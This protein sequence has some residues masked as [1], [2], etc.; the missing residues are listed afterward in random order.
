MS[1]NLEKFTVKSR[2]AL[3]ESRELAQKMNH[4]EI[5]PEHLLFALCH[6]TDGVVPPL[7]QKIGVEPDK[8][9]NHSND[10]LKR[11]PSVTGDSNADIY[12]SRDSSS[13]LK[14]SVKAAENLKDDYISTEHLF[15]ALVKNSKGDLGA[16]FKAL[17]IGEESILKVL[18][19]VRGTQKVT[20]QTPENKYQVLERFSIDLTALARA[21]KLDPVIGR[22]NEVRRILQVL[23]RRTKNNP[24][25]IGEPGVGKTAIIEGLAQRIIN[26]DVPESMKHKRLIALDLGS[27]LAGAKFRGEFEERLKAVLK[28]V[29]ASNGSIILFIDELHTVAGAGNAEGAMDAGNLLKPALARG[30]LH[31]IGAT[32]LNEYQKHIE[33]DAAL[34]RRFQQVFIAE[35]SVE[36]TISILRGLKE[37]YDLHHGVRIMDSALVSAA[38]LSNRYIS[39]RFLP[40]K[41]ID[42]M[43]EAASKLRIEIDSLPTEIDEIDRK[44][45][46][47][48]I[49]EQAL[50]KEKDDISKRQLEKVHRELSELKEK[51]SALKAQWLAEKESIDNIQQIKGKLDNL[52]AEEKA[53]E[54]EGN[55]QR[56]AELRYDTIP[57]LQEE[58]ERLNQGAG[59][60]R[61][62]SMIKEEVSEQDIAEVVSRWTGIPV[63]KMLSSEK[64]KIIK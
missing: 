15:L 54:R 16:I 14:E 29:L 36:D 38:V 45:T 56:A 57:R 44:V 10:I 50:N 40:D 47:L 63:S 9:A 39:D 55:L 59:E 20:D 7:L 19:E 13:I 26:G 4:Q 28:E 17:G 64:E 5:Y 24:V 31:C 49:E 42:L 35:P 3:E 41:A 61:E 18:K 46:R 43:D 25:L 51:N 22:D 62:I 2:E 11:K 30:E 12:L 58:L 32:T 34:E 33:K 37:K 48:L 8:L 27:L 21:D 52:Q 6:Q 53:A 23:C 1:L 60:R